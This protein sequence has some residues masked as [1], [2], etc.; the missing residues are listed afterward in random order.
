MCIR[1]DSV[2]LSEQ[3]KTENIEKQIAMVESLNE[4]P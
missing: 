1:F 4:I 3:E 2:D